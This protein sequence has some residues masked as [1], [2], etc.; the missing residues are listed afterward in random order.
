MIKY[1]F[2]I[3][4]FSV[5]I[6]SLQALETYGYYVTQDGDTVATKIILPKFL[7]EVNTAMFAKIGT[8]DSATGTR[9]SFKPEE[10]R[11]FGF[12]YKNVQH[13]FVTKKFG[14]NKPA[15]YE[16]RRRGA[17]LNLYSRLISGGGGQN[18]YTTIECAIEKPDG[19]FV[20]L[21]GTNSSQ[22]TK[23]KLKEF[24]TD[25]EIVQLINVSFNERDS[26]EDDTL[27]LVDEINTK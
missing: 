20:V 2:L 3:T 11:G 27:K 9:K 26:L 10:I 1:S 17:K 24:F 16:I 25:P 18:T 13:N 6:L 12:N 23:N 4:L 21:P 8:F 19:T 22:R 5:S 14:E 15:F 7:G